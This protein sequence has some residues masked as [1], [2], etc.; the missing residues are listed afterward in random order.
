VSDTCKRS[1]LMN[2]ETFLCLSKYLIERKC[3]HILEIDS[4]NKYGIE[5]RDS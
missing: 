1:P 3:Y 2:I 5:N 4:D